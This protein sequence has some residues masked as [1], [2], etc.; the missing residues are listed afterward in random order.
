MPNSKQYIESIID[1]LQQ[2]RDRL[3]DLTDETAAGLLDFLQ[4][5]DD[6]VWS[7]EDIV[8]DDARL[9]ENVAE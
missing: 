8:E 9:A 7:W 3:P 2:I 6:E 5:T 1:G 4:T